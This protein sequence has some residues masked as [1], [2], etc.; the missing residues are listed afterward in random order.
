M[1]L[2]YATKTITSVIGSTLAVGGITHGFFEILQGNNP[3]NNL[4]IQSISEE[5]QRWPNGEEAF[6]LIPNFLVTGIIAILVSLIIVYWSI[7][8]IHKKMVEVYFYYFLYFLHWLGE[9]LGTLFTF[10][11]PGAMR[12]ECINL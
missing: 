5:H 1:N 11:Q 9:V 8:A 4:I 10:C 2:N 3:T 12:Q 6:T 7:F